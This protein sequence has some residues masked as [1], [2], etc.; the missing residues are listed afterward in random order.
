MVGRP[1]RFPV[2][3]FA[4]V[5]LAAS[6]LAA[7][8]AGDAGA[9]A[10]AS[11]ARPRVALVLSGGGAK[12]I[13]HV[14]VLEVLEELRIPIDFIVGTS[15]GAIVGALYAC[16]WSPKAI[17]EM[18]AS[19]DWEGLFDDR[20]PRRAVS[21]RRRQ[22]QGQFA[23]VELGIKNGALAA[24]R[25]LIAGQDLGF[26]LEKLTLSSDTAKTFD[27]LAIPFRA[28]AADVRSGRRVVLDRGDLAD[29][30]RASMAVPG[31]FAPVERDGMV[32]VDGGILDNLPVDVALA[33]GAETV[34]AVALEGADARASAARSLIDLSISVVETV[35]ADNMRRQRDLL[36]E[37]DEIITVDTS[38]YTGTDF[39]DSVPIIRRGEEAARAAAGALGRLAVDESS[40]AA[41]LA[42]Q[43]RE[44]S[45]PGSIDFVRVEVDGSVAPERVAALMQTRGGSR[46]DLR[47]LQQ[48][49]DRIYAL[50][51]FQ[52]VGFRIVD[53]AAGRGLVITAKEKPY[54]P[55][56]LR[57]ALNA[58]DDFQGGASYTVNG[59]Y[60]VTDLNRLGGEWTT[61][62][63]AGRTLA[64]STDFHQPLDYA[65]RLSL[66]GALT[67]GQTIS[68]FYDNGMREAQ[69]RVT[70]AE[71]SIAAG[72]RPGPSLEI[73]TGLSGAEERAGPA[74]GDVGSPTIDSTIVG[75]ESGLAWD[76]LE[77]FDLLKGGFGVSS[78]VFVSRPILGSDEDYDLF[79]AAAAT[80]H[81]MGRHTV[82]GWVEGGTSRGGDSIPPTRRYSLGG[83]LHLAG[84]RPGQISGLH[85]GLASL[86]YL[87]RV[88]PAL[89]TARYGFYLGIVAEAGGVWDG[90]EEIAVESMRPGG[91][92]IAA[93]VTP[94][95][96]LYIAYG[97][98]SGGSPYGNLYLVLGQIQ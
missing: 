35:T 28:V 80:A 77:G 68:D 50:G 72:L 60:S 90:P 52:T 15:M 36:R 25:G 79:E 1:P 58:S 81:T 39:A 4:L 82:Q 20:P 61:E 74:I 18:I 17:Q 88:A 67:V 51:Q 5:T 95:G 96:P 64:L 75:W 49:I 33:T 2:L 66:D 91:T 63:F 59:E 93:F 89:D 30:L 73:W 62:A 47:V 71:A 55:R 8:D 24:P 84:Y 86:G 29:A 44:P 27:D 26:L 16:G 37:G 76:R 6:R 57:F 94:L 56:Y 9:A 13:A 21:L 11:P 46:L 14:G 38:P 31:A 12:G 97:Y 53:E 48:D 69:Y 22:E 34:I 43:R 42:R 45:D 98:A 65:A 85:Y 87:F 70:S 7:G 32:L 40:Y 19:T 92:L 41:F 10:A 83:L 3:A 78:T 54:G 23:R